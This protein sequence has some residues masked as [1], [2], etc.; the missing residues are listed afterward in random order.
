VFPGSC[1]ERAPTKISGTF[2]GGATYLPERILVPRRPGREIQGHCIADNVFLLKRHLSVSD[3]W[4]GLGS[5]NF[6]IFYLI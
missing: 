6:I 5:H 4:V 1:V 3:G 2:G